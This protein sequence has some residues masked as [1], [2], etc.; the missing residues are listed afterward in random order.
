MIIL[1]KI[2]NKAELARLIYPH[3]KSAP[4]SLNNKLKRQNRQKF[5]EEDKEKV[6]E[7]LMECIEEIR[8][9]KC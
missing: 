3:N 2:L 9:I 1:P 4:S 6:I 8:K 7:V 5:T